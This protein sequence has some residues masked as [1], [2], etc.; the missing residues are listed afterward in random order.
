MDEL[1]KAI[2]K[3]LKF[4]NETNIRSDTEEYTRAVR[5]LK[6]LLDIKEKLESK[7]QAIEIPEV[8]KRLTPEIIALLGVVVPA[9]TSVIGIV[10]IIR[11]EELNVITSKAMAFVLKSRI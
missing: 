10:L 9:L 4:L 11:H 2:D 3:V 6:E 8:R 7:S 1:N 5:N